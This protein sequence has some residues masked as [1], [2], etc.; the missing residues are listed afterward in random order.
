NVVTLYDADLDEHCPYLVMEFVEGPTLRALVATK[1]KLE[2]DD[3]LGIAA[4]LLAGLQH[5]HE[6]GVCHRDLKPENVLMLG[7]HVPKLVDFGLA[8]SEGSSRL[9]ADGM[10]VGTPMYMSPEQLRGD[11]GGPQSD[12]YAFGMLLFHLLTGSHPV[13]VSA[14]WDVLPLKLKLTRADL[15]KQLPGAPEHVFEAIC[16][17]LKT[18]PDER[19]ETA[20]RTAEFLGIA[21]ISGRVP[22]LAASPPAAQPVPIKRQKPQ[23]MRPLVM[24]G[25]VALAAMGAGTALL[26][27]DRGLE[28]EGLTVE[29]VPGGSRVN[30]RTRKPCSGR[31]ETRGRT[32][33][34][35]APSTEHHV[36]VT[37]VPFAAPQ[38][39]RLLDDAG[40]TAA[41]FQLRALPLRPH[42]LILRK[43][44]SLA[45]EL[46][47]PAPAALTLEVLSERGLAARAVL[48]PTAS[49]RAT[50]SLPDDRT[51][52]HLRVLSDGKSVLET[53]ALDLVLQA[54][55][56]ALMSLA[57]VIQSIRVEELV[58]ATM[59]D[60][61]SRVNALDIRRRLDTALERAHWSY[62]LAEARGAV[63]WALGRDNADHALKAVVLYGMEQMLLVDQAARAAGLPDRT[64]LAEVLGTSRGPFA[65]EPK[66]SGRQV[67]VR[68]PSPR[69]V[70]GQMTSEIRG[71]LL[72]EQWVTQLDFDLDV[73][74]SPRSSAAWVTLD[75]LHAS[76]QAVVSVTLNPGNPS[77]VTLILPGNQAESSSGSTTLS[78]GFDPA[79]LLPGK[80]V[81]RVQL[82]SLPGTVA[83]SILVSR[84]K[85]TIQ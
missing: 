80:N 31:V 70:T 65:G 41:S 8:R 37:G 42:P 44:D 72:S 2:L 66:V 53:E 33:G 62:A 48:P 78:H 6:C 29:A 84:V 38:A 59:R 58:A 24:A 32:L 45:F 39:A 7:G 35:G 40:E 64:G 61:R 17:C 79:Y 23:W 85:L 1:K 63:E 26:Q 21:Q 67:E 50:L 11:V 20:L 14:G 15:K 54:P 22:L 73:P 34:G 5:L 57:G 56:S 18:A 81:V 52:F 82:L 13:P 28:P 36:D 51:D 25:A 9:T 77:S 10:M 83:T 47:L 4:G 12:I 27:R 68:P 16:R 69:K 74:S 19:F 49:H 43:G 60:L 75:L 30:W 46:D 71:L 55:R 76:P 3:A